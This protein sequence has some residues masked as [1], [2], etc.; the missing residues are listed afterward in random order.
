MEGATAK[1]LLPFLLV[2]RTMVGEFQGREGS[3]LSSEDL[4]DHPQEVLLDGAYAELQSNNRGRRKYEK[5]GIKMERLSLEPIH[6]PRIPLL[7]LLSTHSHAFP[8]PSSSI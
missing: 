1:G 5:E 8:S 4:T 2:H 3:I 6:A 7:P